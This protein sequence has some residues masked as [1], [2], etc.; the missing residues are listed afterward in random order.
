M[1][2]S[3]KVSTEQ[4]IDSKRWPLMGTAHGDTARRRHR[5]IIAKC[6]RH[7]YKAQLVKCSADAEAM[8]QRVEERELPTGGEALRFSFPI[9]GFRTGRH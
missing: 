7:W 4:A 9:A 3:P 2:D 1:A 8:L 6:L 5:A